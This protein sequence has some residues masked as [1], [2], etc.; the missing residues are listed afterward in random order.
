MSATYDAATNHIYLVGGCDDPQGNAYQKEMDIYACTSLTAQTWAYNPDDGVFL[1]LDAAPRP[2]YRHTAANV[3]GKIWVLGGRTVT[4]ELITEIDVYDPM[5]KTW[6]TVGNLPT[7]L[8]RS[9]QASFAVGPYLY[10]LGGYD[11][12]YTASDSLV[13]A[14]TTSVQTDGLVWEPLASMAEARGDVHAVTVNGRAYVTG[15][16][17]HD[18]GYCRPLTSTERYDYEST[19]G[20]W[21]TIGH[22]H[23]G[24]ADKALVAVKDHLYA[25]GGESKDDELCNGDPGEYTLA[26]GDV[27]VL[28]TTNPGATPQWT[29]VSSD[30]EER[31]FRFVGAPWPRTNSVYVLGG[32]SFFEPSCKCFATSDTISKYTEV[33]SSGSSSTALRGLGITGMMMMIVLTVVVA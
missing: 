9:D 33:E 5:S 6:S 18:D 14:D 29:V 1:S 28:D 26:L 25:V 19:D 16:Y 12:A 10:V 11:A 7:D 17:T 27:E 3:E 24:R 30:L 15:G 31:R 23:T 4:D 2:R 13:R 22:L 8:Q 32:Q 21:T 20:Q